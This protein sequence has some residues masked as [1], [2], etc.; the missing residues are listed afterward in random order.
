M[1]DRV[2]LFSFLLGK[3]KGGVPQRGKKKSKKKK[4]KIQMLR[5]LIFS[6]GSRSGDRGDLVI[7][8]QPEGGNT[9]N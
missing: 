7:F 5:S 9:E 8:L 3:R 4:R 6:G 1:V 2:D